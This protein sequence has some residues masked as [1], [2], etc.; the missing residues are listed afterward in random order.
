LT[1]SQLVDVFEQDDFH[2]KAPLRLQAI[3]GTI[4]HPDLPVG[5]STRGAWKVRRAG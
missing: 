1:Q 2:V 3:S 4:F 5:K